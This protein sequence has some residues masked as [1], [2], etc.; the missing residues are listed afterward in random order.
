MKERKSRPRRSLVVAL[1]KQHSDLD[2]LS[3]LYGQ[4]WSVTGLVRDQ[5]GVR[6]LKRM[7]QTNASNAVGRVG[8]QSRRA[9]K[10]RLAG[11][12]RALDPFVLAP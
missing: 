11:G 5:A 9:V 1:G 10:R 12:R 6:F 7:A 4:S 3:M 2:W 8:A